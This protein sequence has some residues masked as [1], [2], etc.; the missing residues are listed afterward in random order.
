MVWSNQI[1]GSHA[2]HNV[3]KA[4]ANVVNNITTLV[5][6]NPSANII[7]NETI[8]TQYIIRQG[9]KFLGKKVR[10]QYENNCSSFINT[11]LSRQ[12]S[13]KTSVINN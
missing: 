1:I 5:E 11:G 3:S 9:L 2:L 8:L 10:L 12:V 13:L 4:Y 6:P 7:T